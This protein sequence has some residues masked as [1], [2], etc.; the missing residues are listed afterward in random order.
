MYFARCSLESAARDDPTDRHQHAHRPRGD[1]SDEQRQ[2][3]TARS[4]D[5]LRDYPSSP[6]CKAGQP[7]CALCHDGGPPAR[8]P[9]GAAIEKKL[10]PGVAR[11]LTDEQYASGLPA[12][13]KAV[14]AAD[15][16]ADGTINLEEISLGTFPGGLLTPPLAFDY[17][18][19]AHRAAQAHM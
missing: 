10:L 1:G 15:S 19:N 4:R 6:I 13:L 14:E 3:S 8:N 16:D 9:F 7:A 17:S 11:P 18:H 2:R 5:V 12:A